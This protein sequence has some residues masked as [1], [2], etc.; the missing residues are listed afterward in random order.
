MFKNGY[1]RHVSVS[2]QNLNPFFKPKLKP[3]CLLLNRLPV[4]D[5]EPQ[6][7]RP[8]GGLQTGGPLPVPDFTRLGLVVDAVAAGS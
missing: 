6:D 2:K 3:K 5:D 4:L 7:G 8:R 1:F